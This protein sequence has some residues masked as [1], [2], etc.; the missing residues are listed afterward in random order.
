M[1]LQ[2]DWIFEESVFLITAHE[3]AF[4]CRRVHHTFFATSRKFISPVVPAGQCF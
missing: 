2:S 4:L 1:N 3:N